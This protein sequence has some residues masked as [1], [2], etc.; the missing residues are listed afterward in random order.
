MW[1]WRPK[2]IIVTSDTLIIATYSY[3]RNIL[4]HVSSIALPVSSIALPV[5]MQYDASV[6][7]TFVRDSRPPSPRDG[8]D[9]GGGDDGGGRISC[10][11]PAPDHMQGAAMPCGNPS[12]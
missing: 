8:D 1:Y 9:D 7:E 4:L 3:T 6:T 11:G 10:P 12:L 5:G 2:D